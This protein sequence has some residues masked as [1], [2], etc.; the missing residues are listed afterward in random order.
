MPRRR[1]PSSRPS[2]SAAP[3][4]PVY[5][6]PFG[7]PQAE[8][9]LWRAGFGPRAGDVD[10]AVAA[11]LDA[12][13]NALVSPS[14]RPTFTGPAPKDDKGRPLA[15]ADA[16]GHDH[17]WWFDRM[18]RTDQP[19]V[20]RMTL[21]W[22]DWFATRDVPA[23]LA[24]RQNATQRTHALGRF[25]LLLREMTR[26]PAMLLWLSGAG[27]DPK[28][29]NENY[30]RELMELF[31][32]GADRGAYGERD[33]RALAAAL[34]GFTNQWSAS[35]GP[36]GFRY[37]RRRHDPRT[38]RALGARGPLDWEDA[39]RLCVEHRLHPSFFVHRL[40]SQFVPTPPD[41]ATAKALAALYRRSGHRIRPVVAAI[42]RHPALHTGPRMVTPPVVHAAGLLRALGRGVSTSSWAW[43]SGLSGQTLFRPP[44]VAG[45]DETRWLDTSTWRGRWQALPTVLDGLLIK[46]DEQ[47]AAYSPTET[48]EEAL[49]AAVRFWGSPTLTPTTVDGLRA[50][51][52]RVEGAADKPW[53]AR[54]YRAM[55]QNGLRFLIATSP[56][57]QT[58]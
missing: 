38:K 23:N 43:L 4:V 34:T 5:H 9:L 11:G 18:V 54:P 45:W 12:T 15:P 46:S 28:N 52:H 51:A 17:C 19:L 8:R 3:A 13:V 2:R 32:L 21:V 50:F 7:R 49:D 14:G 37:D 44:N 35:R 29:P 30:A 6:G 10:R 33:V 57:L 16:W 53:K 24:L 47:V 31:T 27:S 58:S 36:Y 42:L 1:S 48:A 25:D 40:W 20:E 41:A 55:R 56:D 22:H 39:C 26:D